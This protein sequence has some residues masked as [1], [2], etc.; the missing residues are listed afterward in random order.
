MGE[1]RISGKWKSI[2]TFTDGPVNYIHKDDVIA[3]VKHLI[4]TDIQEG[5]FN[6][7]APEHPL[8]SKVHQK[9]AKDFGFT[10]GTFKGMT[11]RVVKS[12]KL[13]KTLSYNFL[14]PN[15]LQFYSL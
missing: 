8:R 13:I 1:D 15:P 3:I 2:S 6:L 4:D 7:V 14:Y 10:L 11:H 9:N 12:D 5:I